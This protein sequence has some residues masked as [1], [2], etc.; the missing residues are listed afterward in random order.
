MAHCRVMKIADR[1]EF[2]SKP[3]PL[4]CAPDEVVLF[5]AKRMSDRNY[6]SIMV[7]DDERRVLGLL[8]E[9]DI[10]RR[11]VAVESDPAQ[12]KISEIM[13]SDLRVARVNDDVVGWL[14][15]MSNERFRRLPVVDDDD[16]LINVITQGDFVS[17]TW[18]D[19]LGQA[20]SLVKQT[21]GDT[22]SLPILLGGVLL[23]TVVIIIAV[24]FGVR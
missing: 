20:K 6:G 18:P 19:L 3:A 11:L 4:T 21:V 7:V 23:Y 10:L 8:T 14:R 2:Q 1:P 12:T 16:R 9:R 17:Y 15:L 22:L 13:T 5:A 24:T